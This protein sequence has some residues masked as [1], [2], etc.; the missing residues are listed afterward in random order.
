MA[1]KKDA[2]EQMWAPWRITYIQSK[3]TKGCIFCR[4]AK[5]KKDRKN[6]IITRKKY[7]FSMLNIY[8]YNNGHVLIAPYRHIDSLQKMTT[9]ER[10]EL[11]DLITETVQILTAKLKAQGFNIGFNI[12]RVAGAGI[13]THLHAHI[14]PRWDADTNFMPVLSSTKVISQS[15]TALY[16]LLKT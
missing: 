3:K 16:N 7:T 5:Q 1:K 4:K 6:F 10:M 8:P 15:L 11:L 9:K 13:D 12:G 14:V 2:L